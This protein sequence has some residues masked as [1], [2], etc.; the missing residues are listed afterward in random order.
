ML[1]T[2]RQRSSR[3]V[4]IRAGLVLAAV[5]GVGIGYGNHVAITVSATFLMS[6]FATSSLIRSGPRWPTRTGAGGRWR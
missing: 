3:A 2:R 4:V 6:L 5:A 1:A